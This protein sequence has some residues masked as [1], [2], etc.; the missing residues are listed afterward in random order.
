[1]RAR[2]GRRGAALAILGGIYI[3]IGL[4][5]LLSD[6]SPTAY[7]PWAWWSHALWAVCGAI[8][9]LSA[10]WPRVPNWPGFVALSI[11][12]TLW[13]FVYG[14]QWVA[15]VIPGGETGHRTGIFTALT[16]S[17][18]VALVYIIAGWRELPVM[19]SEHRDV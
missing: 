4:S 19:T 9:V 14:W 5:R 11:P 16:W 1:M 15:Y 12:A 17:A 7:I 8:A 10:P 3:L 2:L 6:P 13:A 18:V